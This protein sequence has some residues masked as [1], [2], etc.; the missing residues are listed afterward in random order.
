MPATIAR[1]VTALVTLNALFTIITQW[2][3]LAT[4]PFGLRSGLAY[5]PLDY[6]AE[7]TAFIQQRVPRNASI[8][9]LTDQPPGAFEASRAFYEARY[10]LAPRLLEPFT[11][12][13]HVWVM[14]DFE[15]EAVGQALANQF[16]LTLISPPNERVKLYTAQLKAS[17]TPDTDKILTQDGLAE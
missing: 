5:T 17:K 9:F 7:R 6:A 16:G 13:K 3:A 4:S 10:A 1:F 12:G 11:P 8:G 15:Q 14:G 2:P